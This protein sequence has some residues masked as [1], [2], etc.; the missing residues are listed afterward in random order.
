M[1]NNKLTKLAAKRA[2]QRQSGSTFVEVLVVLVIVATVLTA[3]ASMMAMSVRV[4]ENNEMQQLAQLKAQEAMEY[5]R[6]ER[7]VRGWGNFY[8]ALENDHN[9]CLNQ[10]PEDISQFAGLATNCEGNLQTLNYFTYSTEVYINKSD[11]EPDAET[12]E[13]TV[14]IYRYTKAG[15]PTNE[16]QAFYSVTQQ[17][18]QY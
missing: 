6:K 5:L 3:L 4:A 1:P 9:Y 18:K 13:A 14:N 8:S 10:L 16:G 12:I 15:E 7:L 17:L 2:R 11:A